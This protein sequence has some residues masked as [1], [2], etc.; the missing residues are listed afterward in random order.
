MCLC[1]IFKTWVPKAYYTV[2]HALKSKYHPTSYY[3]YTPRM[4]IACY[5]RIQ[6]SLLSIYLCFGSICFNPKGNPLAVQQNHQLS[7]RSVIL[8][9]N[10]SS[11]GDDWKQ[12]FPHNS[13][14]CKYFFFIIHI[15][16]SQN[17]CHWRIATHKTP[18]QTSRRY[19]IP[20]IYVLRLYCVTRP[21]QNSC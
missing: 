19:T 13:N 18:A 9:E 16:E 20:Y 6:I 21:Y 10:L 3:R 15:V 8:G 7:L 5:V 14:V 2:P 11:S 17:I 4:Y 12:Y 1:T